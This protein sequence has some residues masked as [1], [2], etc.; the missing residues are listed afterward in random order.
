MTA[1]TCILISSNGAGVWRVS[2]CL[3]SNFE[4]KIQVQAGFSIVG[5]T[6]MFHV[7]EME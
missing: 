2:R 3:S 5:E 7:K 4:N 1:A 6:E